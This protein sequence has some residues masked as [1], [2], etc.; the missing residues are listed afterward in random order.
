MSVVF[1]L[2]I[3]LVIFIVLNFLENS[4]KKESPVKVEPKCKPCAKP[5]LLVF[6]NFDHKKFSHEN[7]IPPNPNVFKLEQQTFDKAFIPPKDLPHVDAFLGHQN[8]METSQG[9]NVKGQFYN[10]FDGITKE[11]HKGELMAC[12]N[13]SCA[14]GSYEQ[15]TNNT[16]AQNLVECRANELCAY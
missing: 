14:V 6:E 9:Y 3:S 16:M 5:N 15:K 12:A 8:P 7:I 4:T 10:Y 11:N 2:F 1:Y 13:L